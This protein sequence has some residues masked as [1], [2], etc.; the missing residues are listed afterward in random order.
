MGNGR[1]FF[2][3]STGCRSIVRWTLQHHRA[4]ERWANR[5]FRFVRCVHA[6]IAGK[7]SIVQSVRSSA[8]TIA[9]LLHPYRSSEGVK[10]SISIVSG[11]VARVRARLASPLTYLEAPVI[12]R[13]SGPRRDHARDVREDGEFLFGESVARCIATRIADQR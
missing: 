1:L 9:P 6:R 8:E 7:I 12:V 11:P 3:G 13:L 5:S 2:R 4:F 10:G